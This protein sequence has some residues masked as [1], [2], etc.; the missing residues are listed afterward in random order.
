MRQ[1]NQEDN[2]SFAFLWLP[3]SNKIKRC[4]EESQRNV[5]ESDTLYIG[6]R[7]DRNREPRSWAEYF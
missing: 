4:N 5:R 6:C 3:P 1:E 7:S 2:S